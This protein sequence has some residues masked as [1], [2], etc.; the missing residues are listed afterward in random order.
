MFLSDSLEIFNV[1]NTL[2]LTNF[3][4]NGNTFLKTGVP[5]FVESTNIENATFLYKAALSEANVKTY[6]MRSSK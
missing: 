2:T 3:L 6:R 1:F 5:F 4:N